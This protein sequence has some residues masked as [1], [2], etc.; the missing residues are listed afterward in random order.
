M[1]SVAPD[2][3][4]IAAA[5]AEAA[6]L[7]RAGKL[8]AFPTE[9]VYGLGAN[10]LDEHAVR[11]I[12][13]AKG[14]PSFNP[15]IVHVADVAAARGL[16]T[17][18]PDE[19][20][21]LATRFWPGPLTLVLPKRPEIPDAVTAGLTAVAVRVP[22]HPIALALLREAGL[23]VAAPSANRSNAVSPTTAAH[24]RKSLGRRVDL[25]LDGGPA[26]VGIESTVL[27]LS[28]E[29]P[30]ILRPGQISAEELAPLVGPLSEGAPV[31]GE[32]P[33][34]SPGQLARHYAPRAVLR[35]SASAADTTRLVAEA[36]AAGARTGAL[37][38]THEVA[39]DRTVRLPSDPAGYARELYAA[40]H[41][42]DDA[43]CAIIVAEALPDSP[44]WA[45]VRDRLRRAATD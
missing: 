44:E 18:W 12:F 30:A 45:G 10:A 24:V 19:A 17:H 33:R 40:L 21:R 25:V 26:M 4:A 31:T 7:L 42:L 5:I 29:R 3:A 37:V 41:T 35:I 11:R 34:R 16:V 39:A 20:E 32:V 2:A 27:D 43:G 15:V 28:G 9:T 23:P 14:R 6:R 36:S 13:E 8:V 38:R 22:A 1:T